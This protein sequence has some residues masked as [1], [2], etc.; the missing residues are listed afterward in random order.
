MRTAVIGCGYVGL[1]TGLTLAEL[2]YDVVLV[3]TDK[4]KLSAVREGRSPF[5]EPGVDELL[6]KHFKA[7]TL[8]TMDD[9]LEASRWAEIV[10]IAVGTPSRE[11]GSMEDRYIRE[12]A[13]QIGRSL[14]SA[15]G[16]RTVVVKS[17]VVPG[18]TIGTIRS[19][20]ERASGKRAGKGFGLA[21]CPEFLREGSAMQDSLHPDRVVVGTLDDRSFET[22]SKLFSP[23]GSIILRTSPTAA[24]MIKYA[25]N[26]FLATKISYVNEMSRLC[27]KLGVDVYDVM[28]GVGLDKRISPHFLRAGV[29]FGGSC[30]PKDVS[31]LIHV[32]KGLDEPT[33]VMDSV[34]R[35]N[36]IQPRHLVDVLERMLGTL[37]KR[38][39]TVLGLA[40]KPDTDDVR[41]TRSLP[42]IKA[43]I[44][45]GAEVGGHDP[46]AALNFRTIA[47][48]MTFF[49]DAATAIEWAD[50]VVL[51]TEWNEY[52]SIDWGQHKYLKAIIDGRRTIDPSRLG[53]IKY[54][55]MGSP[56]P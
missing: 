45:R 31:A 41:E 48:D 13:R 37:K 39:V 54:W 35:T 9:A 23:L 15:R 47:P 50:A 53:R 28:E 16:F 49:D 26:T 36:D 42:V 18:T 38:K 14:K 4:R 24:E 32:A 22:M 34:M 6:K 40:F 10:F 33:P 43:L 30:F 8:R 56:L 52:R 27:E 21:M 11:D 25:S 29:G 19:A 1:T 5:Y 7:G 55:S 51:M 12:A 46:K 17:T 2:G 44:R 3:D 20:L